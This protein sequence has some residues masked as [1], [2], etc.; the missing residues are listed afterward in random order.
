MFSPNS[1]DSELLKTILEP[2]LA[3]FKYWLEKSV[4]FL[5]A[6]ELSF[7]S[8]DEQA[9]LLAR[10]LQVQQEVAAAHALYAVT[11]GKAGIDPS[12]LIPWHH[13]VVECWQAAKRFRQEKEFDGL[14]GDYS[15]A[16]S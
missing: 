5:T 9:D 2:L 15:D 8:T 1:A 14:S 6:N 7:M 16:N 11:D 3:D 13:L 12:V 10:A 4:D